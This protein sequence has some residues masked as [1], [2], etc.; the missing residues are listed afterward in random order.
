ME[1]LA[2]RR[3]LDLYYRTEKPLPE[4]AEIAR[5]IRMRDHAA[6]I[7]DVL[8]E[9]F[10]PS[11]DGHRHARCDA[12]IE[13]MQDKQAKAKASAAASVNARSANA[14]RTLNER[15]TKVE[16]PTPTPTPKER[17]GEILPAATASPPE[18]ENV[19]FA[20]QPTAAG[21]LCKA[22]KAAGVADVNPGHPD[23]LRL[24]AAKIPEETFTAAAA[25]LAGRGR[26][27]FALLLRTVE[28][29]WTDAQEAGPVAEAKA[30][31]PWATRGGVEG[32]AKKLGMPRWDECC[33]FDFY[34]G[35]VRKAFEDEQRG[36]A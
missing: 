7:R 4:P 11:P 31:D 29:Q 15:S 12:E 32:I 20:H 21:L 14:Q 16:L 24:M 36:S 18:V 3:M 8:N 33:T 13:R 17:T 27:R 1:D 35:R 26:G 19:V 28:G 25:S 22:I 6:T 23:L 30:A 9:F 2:Y 5:L 10:E 34:L